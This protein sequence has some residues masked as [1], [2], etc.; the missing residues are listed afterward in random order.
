MEHFGGNTCFFLMRVS[1]FSSL[2]V[3]LAGLILLLSGLTLL[4]FTELNRRAVER[5]LLEQ[6]EVQAAA[7]MAATVDGVEAV[8]GAVERMLRFVAR[9]LD[10]RTLTTAEVERLARNVVIDSPNVDGCIIAFELPAAGAATERVGVE[11]HRTTGANQFVTRDLAA[12]APGHWTSEGYRAVIDRAQTVWSEP[13]FDRG[14]S[15][16]NVVRVSVPVFRT[17]G[18]EREPVGVVSARL[19]LDWL[20]RLANVQEFSDTSF[21]IIFSRSGR[22]VIHPKATYII[23]E[24]IETLAEKTRVPELVTIRQNIIAKRQGTLRY[25]EPLAARRVHVNYRPAKIAGWGVIVGYDDAE[26]LKGQRAFRGITALYLGGLLL[27]L[28]GIV[29]LVT[30]FALRPLGQLALAADE[31]GKKNLEC[32]IAAPQRDDEVGRLTQALRDMRDALKAQHLERRWASQS[33]EHQ[34]RYNQLIIDSISE[35]VLVLTKAMNITRVN[36]ACLRATGL[37]EV[38]LIKAPLARMVRLAPRAGEPTA[39]NAEM[40]NQALK[41]GRSV[42]DLPAFVA[43]KNGQ[44]IAV[45]LTLVPLLDANRV[46]GGVVTL[47]VVTPGVT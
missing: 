27:A 31:I 40:L 26:F 8:I 34:L 6:A 36:P 14:G 9:D 35:L 41:D 3:R 17:V 19:D 37:T 29:I 45:I 38:E 23:A 25:A 15:D 39:T 7:S 16:R 12:T 20:R 1:F 24:T 21:T 30:R 18:E 47:R 5:I 46:V 10:G 43:V 11:V 33:L 13:F 42:R 28:A 44:E 2:P 22:L 32:E 4:V